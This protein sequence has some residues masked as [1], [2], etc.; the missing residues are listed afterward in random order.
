MAIRNS[1]DVALDIL[2]ARVE[3]A[4][5]WARAGKSNTPRKVLIR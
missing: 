2:V 1:T 4:A 5:R 3:R